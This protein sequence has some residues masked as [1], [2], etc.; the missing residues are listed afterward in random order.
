MP[1]PQ[2]AERSVYWIFGTATLSNPL[3]F[4]KTFFPALRFIPDPR[5]ARIPRAHETMDRIRHQP[6]D[7]SHTCIRASGEKSSST[8][9]DLLSLL[10]KANMSPDVGEHHR[11]TDSDVLAQVPTFLLARHET[12]STATTWALFAL[13]QSPES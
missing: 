6:L 13:T 7:E 8:A 11:M 5:N 9:R 1:Y 10:V 12:T 3:L 4:V 2:R